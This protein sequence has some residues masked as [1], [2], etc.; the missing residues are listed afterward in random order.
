M[1]TTACVK[2]KKD[3]RGYGAGNAVKGG[4]P[5]YGGPFIATLD[6][7]SSAPHN[8]AGVEAQRTIAELPP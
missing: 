1:T 6:S 2:Q 4:G 5:S 8:R 7:V 3:R